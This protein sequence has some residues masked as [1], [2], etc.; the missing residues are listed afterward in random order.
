MANAEQTVRVYEQLAEW[1][2]GQGQPKLRDWFLVLAADTAQ[3]AGRADVAE[4]FRGRLLQRNPHHLLRPFV[5]FAEAL[6]SADI[7]GYVADLRVTYPP[8]VARDLLDTNTRNAGMAPPP[9]GPARV[10]E[11]APPFASDAAQER[12][13]KVYRVTTTEPPAVESP[14]ARPPAAAGHRPPASTIPESTWVPPPIGPAGP[15]PVPL[16][17][18]SHADLGLEHAK[19]GSGFDESDTAAGRWVSTALIVLLSLA[20]LSVAIYLMLRPLLLRP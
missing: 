5:S 10:T 12:D 14:P 11:H 20:G 6:Q 9:R 15:L 8:D 1:Y 18:P 3:S 19:G 17:F 7:K 2:E 4:Q 16:Q 13:L